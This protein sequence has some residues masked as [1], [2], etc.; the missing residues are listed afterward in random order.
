MENSISES[1]LRIEREKYD[2]YFI[3]EWLSKQLKDH[4]F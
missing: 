1:L 4:L 2:F 3:F